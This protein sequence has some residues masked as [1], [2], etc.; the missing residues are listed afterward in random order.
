MIKCASYETSELNKPILSEARAYCKHVSFQCSLPEC[1]CH[2]CQSIETVEKGGTTQQKYHFNRF[3]LQ[4]LILDCKPMKFSD[5]VHRCKN[6]ISFVQIPP[7]RLFVLMSIKLINYECNFVWHTLVEAVN[8][9]T[10]T[11]KT[12]MPVHYTAILLQY[13][14]LTYNTLWHKVVNMI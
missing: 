8:S 6:S 7:L 12:F 3:S 2:K 10:K 1:P 9:K 11:K 13:K 5:K 4:T 14:K